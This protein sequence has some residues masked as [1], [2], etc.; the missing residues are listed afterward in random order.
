MAWMNN[1]T[2]EVVTIPAGD[3]KW[4]AWMRVARNYR[5]RI[6]MKDAT[7]R[8][9][10]DFDGFLRDVSVVLPINTLWKVT[11]DNMNRIMIS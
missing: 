2:R 8:R 11:E 3:I 10:E 7:N 6:G 1:E 5:L 4:A 9:R